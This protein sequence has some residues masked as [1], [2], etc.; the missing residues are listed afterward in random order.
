VN[1]A[2]HPMILSLILALKKVRNFSG[3]FFINRTIVS[4][5]YLE[6]SD[7]YNNEIANIICEDI[8]I[9]YLEPK[10]TIETVKTEQHLEK[11]SKKKAK[12]SQKSKTK[13]PILPSSVVKTVFS[14]AEKPSVAP[15]LLV[16]SKETLSIDF[17][18]AKFV[19]KSLNNIENPYFK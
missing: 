14:K 9:D 11:E 17:V 7:P 10:V 15:I 3:V 5:V 6:P 18:E 4:L 16:D 12:K 1:C 13:A 2:G 8:K 19:C